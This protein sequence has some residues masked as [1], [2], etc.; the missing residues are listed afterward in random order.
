MVRETEF[1][2]GSYFYVSFPLFPGFTH[3]VIPPLYMDPGSPTSHS[4]FDCSC[5][6]MSAS[7]LTTTTTT[8][9]GRLKWGTPPVIRGGQPGEHTEAD[10]AVFG[11][12][13]FLL[14]FVNDWQPQNLPPELINFPQE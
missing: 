4:G 11:M 1:H 14:A 6:G 12:N 2:L 7:S 8:T 3:S 13:G 5:P 9:T 10:V